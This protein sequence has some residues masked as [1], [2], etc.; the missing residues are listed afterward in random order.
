MHVRPCCRVTQNVTSSVTNDIML[1]F[2]E[3][4]CTHAK[5]T[6]HSSCSHFIYA[7]TCK[8]KT[9]RIVTFVRRIPLDLSR[10]HVPAQS[11]PGPY[12]SVCSRPLSV[13]SE[14]LSPPRWIR[15]VPACPCH[16]RTAFINEWTIERRCRWIS[17]KFSLTP[18]AAAALGLK[19]IVTRQIH[20][21]GIATDNLLLHL[22]HEIGP[23]WQT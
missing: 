14:P 10:V 17:K 6:K 23:L 13:S 5:S 2:L 3:M 18:A 7:Q 22:H 20:P 12:C 21:K 16:R 8:Y 9:E 19:K 11:S 15:F 4:P 1:Y